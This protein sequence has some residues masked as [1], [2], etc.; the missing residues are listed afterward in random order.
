[1][2]FNDISLVSCSPERLVQLTG[3][4]ASIRPIA[5]TRPRGVGQEQDQLLCAELIASPKE[6]AEHVMLVDLERNDLGKVCR[7]GSVRVE[8]F[9][10]IEQYS[11]VRHLVSDVTGTLQPG[12]APLDLVKA[13]LP[14]AP[15]P[16]FRS[17]AA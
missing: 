7:Y 6:R 14:A 12:T 5:G 13:D 16:G 4:T 9:M 8:E 3:S 17:F 10:T 15:L 11:H 1:M 2:R